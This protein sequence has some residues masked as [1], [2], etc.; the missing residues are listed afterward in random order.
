[1]QWKKLTVGDGTR[2]GVNARNFDPSALG[3][4]KIRLLD[5]ASS[6]KYIA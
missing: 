4:V 3:N 1:M 2:T 6:W 5:G